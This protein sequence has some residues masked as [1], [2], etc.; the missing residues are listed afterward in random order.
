VILAA[1]QNTRV[2]KRRLT[3]RMFIDEVVGGTQLDVAAVI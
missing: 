2:L 1:T 3:V